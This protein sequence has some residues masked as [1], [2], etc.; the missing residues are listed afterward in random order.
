MNLRHPGPQRVLGRC[1]A[2]V[3]GPDPV[4]CLD[5]MDCLD[6][7]LEK[8]VLEQH[9]FTFS[10]CCLR[11]PPGVVAGAAGA[12]FREASFGATLLH[13][14]SLLLSA[15]FPLRLLPVLPVLNS[16]KLVLEQHSCTFAHFC[17]PRSPP[18]GCCRCCWV[19]NSSGCH[20]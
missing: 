5:C 9:S 11:P 18:W 10:Q 20:I 16:Q 12:E 15:P 17:C 1:R 4:D 8:L 19:L 13:F 2:A 6:P 7:R 3:C 14:C